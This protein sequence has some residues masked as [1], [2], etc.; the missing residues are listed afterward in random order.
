MNELD[1]VATIVASHAQELPQPPTSG[2]VLR[3][4][5]RVAA[6]AYS[7]GRHQ[8]EIDGITRGAQVASAQ[9]TH[10]FNAIMGEK[11]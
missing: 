10:A 2:D 4:L 11:V 7:A 3:I 9:M 8:G 1:T 5:N 6:A